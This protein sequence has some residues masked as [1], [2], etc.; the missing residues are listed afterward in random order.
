MDTSDFDDFN[1]PH[2]FG[3]ASRDTHA[4]GRQPRSGYRARPHR[5]DAIFA[6]SDLEAIGALRALH[7]RHVRI[8][9]DIA[10]VSFDGTIDSQFSWPA[11]TVVQQ[12]ATALAERMF[13]AALDPQ[14]TPDLQLIDTTLVPRQSCGCL[15]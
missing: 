5:P 1:Q 2:R 12:D 4:R 6:D 9:E 13:Q 8:P 15:K 14:N 3:P 10:I 11:L 7:E